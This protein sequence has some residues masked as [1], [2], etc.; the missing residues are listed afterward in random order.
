LFCNLYVCLICSVLLNWGALNNCTLYPQKRKTSEYQLAAI[1]WLLT[2]GNWKTEHL[3]CTQPFTL[4]LGF[5]YRKKFGYNF[6]YRKSAMCTLHA[7]TEKGEKSQ[8]L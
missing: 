6:K 4:G 8:N 5:K 2:L 3:L 7:S 1:H